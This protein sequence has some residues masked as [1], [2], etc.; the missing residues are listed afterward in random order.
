LVAPKVEE[1]LA[2]TLRRALV[3][4]II[5]IARYDSLMVP[6]MGSRW[7][8]LRQLRLAF[9]SVVVVNLVAAVVGPPVTHEIDR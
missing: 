4:V 8:P 7:T 2:D 9:E 6:L 5:V 1:G 3:V